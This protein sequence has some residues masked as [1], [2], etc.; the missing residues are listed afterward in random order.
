MGSATQNPVMECK[1]KN[2]VI[3]GRE[4]ELSWEGDITL[5]V[6]HLLR[7]A[8]KFRAVRDDTW[9]CKLGFAHLLLRWCH[10]Q[11]PIKQ[12]CIV[13]C[14]VP[15]QIDAALLGAVSHQTQPRRV[16]LQD[17]QINQFGPLFQPHGL[18]QCDFQ[19]GP[20]VSLPS[21]VTVS[22]ANRILGAT[23]L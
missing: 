10:K 12:H 22:Y 11:L 20:S 21:S 23:S 7:A 17:Q 19:R 3:S 18:M 6:Q 2:C 14:R 5:V 1:K 8:A 13:I 9:V 16:D 15:G 4:A